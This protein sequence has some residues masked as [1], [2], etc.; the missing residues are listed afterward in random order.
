MS[1]GFVRRVLLPM[2][3]AMLG[4]STF[5]ILRQ[6]NARPNPSKE[7]LY[8]VQRQG[9]EHILQH[10]V[11]QIPYWRDRLECRLRPDSKEDVEALLASVPVLT[12]AEIGRNREAMRWQLAPGKI[13]MHRSGGTTDDNL[14]FYWGRARQSWDRAMRYRGLS[15]HG[16]FPGDR[17]LHVWPRYPGKRWLDKFK[18]G[19]RDWRDWLTNDEV[20]DLRPMSPERLD[21][22]LH[23]CTRYRPAVL[24]GYPSW[25]TALAERI[26]AAHPRFRLSTLRLILCTGEVLFAFQRRLIAETFGV[27]VAQEYG[28]Q[29][30][31]LIAHEDTSG[32]LRLNAEQMVVEILR[33]GE[34]AAPGELGEVVITHFYTEIMP[35][36]RYATGDV[37]RRPSSDESL[38]G[39]SGHPVFPQPEGRTS[40]VL[41]TTAGEPCPMRP[42]VE[43]LIEHTGMRE[44]SLYQPEADHI[45]V[46][47]IEGS[48]QARR[49]RADAEDVLRSLLGTDLQLE[50]RRGRRFEPFTSGKR[51]FVCSPVGMRLIAHDKESGM[52]RA[53][54]WPQRLEQESL[55]KS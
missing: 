46:L 36:I 49:V 9:L 54:A 39:P 40:D 55:S 24:I 47:V 35:F 33:D 7:W 44:F 4:R 32:I 6:L 25:L 11:N 48:D 2:H 17:V 30:S 28:S 51:R 20:I 43:A 27:G 31:G 38:G 53:R 41:A 23:F 37:V 42:V 1:P 45:I 26:R 14:T 21:A 29:D 5:S 13:L 52:A 15:R 10:V 16:I 19:L 18:L 50:W 34:T 8:Q 12:R 22:V 3:E